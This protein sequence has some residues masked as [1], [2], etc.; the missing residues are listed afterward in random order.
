MKPLDG[1][2]PKEACDTLFDMPEIPLTSVQMILAA[3][4]VAVGSAVQGI[5]GFGLALIAAPLLLL[6]DPILVPGPLLTA[7]L[8]LTLLLTWRE[9]GG[10]DHEALWLTVGGRFVG[11]IPAVIVM[12]LLSSK[13]FDLIFAAVVIAAVVLS[14]MGHTLTPTRNRAIT[15]GAVAGF[16]G[17]IT[18]IGGP[19]VALLYQ[20][21]HGPRFRGTMSGFFLFGTV[22]SLLGL[23]MIGHYGL[24]EAYLG[25]LLVPGM[26]FG[27]LA[28]RPF[29]GGA[30]RAGLRPAILGLSL[31]SAIALIW[32]SFSG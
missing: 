20:H 25:L 29:V 28:S 24:R 22:L 15:A 4:V 19:P 12:P 6:I 18:S 27:F 5:I 17:T 1:C 8:V 2:S 9:W 21:A 26:L 10:V 30:D 7:G 31:A 11:T 32:R 3:L 14:V 23:A 13:L 16:T